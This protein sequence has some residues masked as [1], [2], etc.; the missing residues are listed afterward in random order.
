MILTLAIWASIAVA[1]A[2]FAAI[3][4]VLRIRNAHVE[5][6][7][8]ESER[9]EE[10]GLYRLAK[11]RLIHRRELKQQR[12]DPLKAIFGVDTPPICACAELPAGGIRPRDGGRTAVALR[13]SS[14]RRGA[15]SPLYPGCPPSARGLS[16][17]A[18]LRGQTRSVA[19]RLA[20][21]FPGPYPPLTLRH[22]ACAALCIGTGSPHN[23]RMDA[24]PDPELLCT[25]R[26]VLSEQGNVRLAILFGSRATGRATA[27]SDLDLAVMMPAPME[28]PQKIA[29]IERI[30]ASTGLPI[31]LIDLRRAGEPLLGQI[32]KH[33]VRLLGSDADYAA[34]ISRHLFDAADFLPYRNRILAER[35][36]A[37][38]GR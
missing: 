37:W 6:Q 33:G 4:L 9:T 30:A 12:D 34:L 11:A 17:M 2:V 3:Y 13:K 10:E 24:H 7:V 20:R 19:S 15:G 26:Q 23:P 36:Q 5:I 8:N 16:P 27:A 38:I 18:A 32:L 31:D 29:W 1:V 22:A 14:P 21:H 35:R 25:L 28:A